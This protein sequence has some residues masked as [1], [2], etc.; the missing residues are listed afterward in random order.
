M[1]TGLGNGL[2]VSILEHK[3]NALLRYGYSKNDANKLQIEFSHHRDGPK[4]SLEAITTI[5]AH[6]EVLWSYGV[7]YPVFTYA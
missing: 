7:D 3:I 4:F 6:E 1:N 5:H 2:I